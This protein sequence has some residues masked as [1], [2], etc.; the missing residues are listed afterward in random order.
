VNAT[1][2]RQAAQPTV[3]AV[4]WSP[5]LV[6]VGMLLALGTAL[7]LLDSPPGPVLALGAAAMAAVLVFSLRDPAAALLAAVPISRFQ[8][9]AL[10][11]A[12]VGTVAL[13]LWLLLADVLPG[14]GAALGP[15]L[16]LTASGVAVATWLPV[17]RDTS[18]AAAVP[19][20]WASAAQLLGDAVGPASDVLTW[21][22]TDPWWVVAAAVVLVALGRHR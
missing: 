5:L 14:D 3:R 15:L 9:R 11:L 19:L 10:R 6:V 8:R 18:V 12:L 21:W 17:D 2:L 4:A 1:A 13:P 7:R 22:V 20:L 16:A